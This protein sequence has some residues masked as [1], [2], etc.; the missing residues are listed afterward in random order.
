MGGAMVMMQVFHVIVFYT[1]SSICVFSTDRRSDLSESNLIRFAILTVLSVMAY[2]YPPEKLSVYLSDDG[3]SELTFYALTQAAIFS[4]H[5]LPYCRNY[6][7]EPLS[8]AAYF[9]SAS[10]PSDTK[11]RQ[12]FIVV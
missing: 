10:H 7:A 8:P 1:A 12:D 2:D 9:K 3:G 5:W 11:H 6:K 4:K